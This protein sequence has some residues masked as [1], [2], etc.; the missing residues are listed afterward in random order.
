MKKDSDMKNTRNEENDKE[1]NKKD[2]SHNDS[3]I[4]EENYDF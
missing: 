2:K 3:S 4:E 1:I